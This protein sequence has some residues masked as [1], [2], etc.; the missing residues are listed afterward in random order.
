M[1]CTIRS[2]FAHAV[3]RFP[4]DST[5]ASLS[6]LRL[7]LRLRGTNLDKINWKC[8][9]VARLRQIYSRL[10][11]S[12]VASSAHW[13]CARAAG[14]GSDSNSNVASTWRLSAG[15]ASRCAP[16]TSTFKK[17]QSRSQ[18][19]LICPILR[20]FSPELII[21]KV[22]RQKDGRCKDITPS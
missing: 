14:S 6:W 8:R 5:Y 1:Q 15:A 13:R 12:L 17:P 3:R 19:D 10:V 7:A 22:G 2:G 11:L 9:R 21:M 4:I 20:R 18:F 16:P